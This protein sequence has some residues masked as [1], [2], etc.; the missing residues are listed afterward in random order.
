M[1]MMDD[2]RLINEV[3]YWRNVLARVWGY[4]I[5]GYQVIKKWLSY[6][7]HALLG[8]PLT[9]DEARGVT[10]IARRL[11]AIILMEPAMNANYQAVKNSCYAWPSLGA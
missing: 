1:R 9:R 6:R 10:N 11:A 4:Y 8:R 3:G 2:N 7:E 5:G